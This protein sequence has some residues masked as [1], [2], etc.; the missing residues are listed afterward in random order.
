MVPVVAKKEHVSTPPSKVPELGQFPARGITAEDYAAMEQMQ[1]Q[2]VASKPPLC[3]SSCEE[4]IKAT[5]KQRDELKRIKPEA[6]VIFHCGSKSE[7][8]FYEPYFRNLDGLPYDLFVTL[9]KDEWVDIDMKEIQAKF[10]QLHN[11]NNCSAGF[12]HV[13]M[14]ENRGMDAGGWIQTMKFM[15]HLGIT[16]DSYRYVLKMHTKR[17]YSV[18]K[19]P[20]RGDWRTLLMN[21]CLGSK[22]QRDWCLLQLRAPQVAMVG[23]SAWLVSGKVWDSLDDYLYRWFFVNTTEPPTRKN[24]MFIGGTMFWANWASISKPWLDR[25]TEELTEMFDTMEPGYVFG[26]PPGTPHIVERLFAYM[27]QLQGLK[28]IGTS[29]PE[30]AHIAPAHGCVQIGIPVRDEY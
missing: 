6:C 4:E 13:I 28:V 10:E 26:D 15:K 27:L 25:N 18:L 30:D 23:A 24:F 9:R 7:L 2:A 8:P 14:M 29:M 16:S 11:N 3:D 22:D 21:S 20:G 19:E 12:T 1:D 17:S 5:K